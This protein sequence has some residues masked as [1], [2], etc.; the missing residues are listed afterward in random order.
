M[1]DKEEKGREDAFIFCEELIFFFFL[2]WDILLYV[3]L[4]RKWTLT[5]KASSYHFKNCS[6]E[7]LTI[8]R[9]WPIIAN[10]NTERTRAT[11]SMRNISFGNN[12]YGWENYPVRGI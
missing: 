4:I 5:K 1:A 2:D 8:K 3:I 12:T 9:Y 10:K 7:N 11:V 6:V